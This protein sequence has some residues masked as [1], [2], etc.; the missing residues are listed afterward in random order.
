LKTVKITASG[1]K[2]KKEIKGHSI[3]GTGMGL[4]TVLVL[5]GFVT[6]YLVSRTVSIR[7]CPWSEPLVE[8]GVFHGGLRDIKISPP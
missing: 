7:L 5:E 8:I 3:W 1:L 2:D 4:D 6:S